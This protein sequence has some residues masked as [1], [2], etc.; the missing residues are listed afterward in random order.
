[1]VMPLMSEMPL[2]QRAVIYALMS[3]TL[4][5]YV[6]LAYGGFEPGTLFLA[7]NAQAAMIFLAGFDAP[8]YA[9]EEKPVAGQAF[10]CPSCW[11]IALRPSVGVQACACGTP[12]TCV[13]LRA[14]GLPP[15][16]DLSAGMLPEPDGVV[17]AA[18]AENLDQIDAGCDE[19]TGMC[20]EREETGKV[21]VRHDGHAG[22]HW[23]ASPNLDARAA[24]QGF[25][26][27]IVTGEQP[28][29]A[30]GDDARP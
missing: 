22:G 20:A 8:R 21:C 4:A 24:R 3:V 14:G 29:R 27:W 17:R 26:R 28:G 10:Q 5:A 11:Q 13:D 2:W 6:A 9:A 12:M 19:P 7:V 15:G 23:F 25:A 30:G 1:M 18:I 16:A